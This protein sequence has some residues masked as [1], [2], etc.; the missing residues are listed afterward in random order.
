V[1]YREPS[2]SL[3]CVFLSHLAIAK[4]CRRFAICLIHCLNSQGAL[5]LALA[6]TCSLSPNAGS[7]SYLQLNLNQHNLVL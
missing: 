6:F 5:A 2:Y 4:S 7:H 1:Q 3:L